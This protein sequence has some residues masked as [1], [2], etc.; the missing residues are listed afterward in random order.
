M[1]ADFCFPLPHLL[2]LPTEDWQGAESRRLMAENIYIY[3]H[4]PFNL[5]VLKSGKKPQ[6]V[7]DFQFQVLF[8]SKIL[9]ILAEAVDGKDAIIRMRVYELMVKVSMLCNLFFSDRSSDPLL[10]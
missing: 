7:N 1:Y 3:L 5:R 6:L 2:A 10:P 8:S 9:P 4:G